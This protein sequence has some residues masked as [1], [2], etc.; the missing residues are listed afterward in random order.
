MRE[1]GDPPET[2]D[3][4]K[5]DERPTKDRKQFTAGKPPGECKISVALNEAISPSGGVDG[6]DGGVGGV[7]GVVISPR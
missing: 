6:A 7:G 2:K 5:T 3:R 4:P 1:G